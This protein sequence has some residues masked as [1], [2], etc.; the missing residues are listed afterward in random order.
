MFCLPL[1]G[2]KLGVM[3]PGWTHFFYFLPHSFVVLPLVPER[4]RVYYALHI[5]CDCA[6]H[7]GE[8]SMRPFYPLS[9]FQVEGFYDP[10]KIFF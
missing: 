9:N 3:E 4:F 8:W 7:T 5:L 2:K 1:F 6:A 10:W